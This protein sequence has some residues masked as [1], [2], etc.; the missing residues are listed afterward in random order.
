MSRWRHSTAEPMIGFTLVVL[1]FVVWGYGHV[2]ELVTF[3]NRVA[4]EVESWSWVKAYAD[5]VEANG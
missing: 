1:A 5:K 4:D 2:P 3:V